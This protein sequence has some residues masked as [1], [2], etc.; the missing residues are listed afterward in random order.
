MPA[1]DFVVMKGDEQVR[2]GTVAAESKKK[3]E[4]F[5]DAIL[6]DKFWAYSNPEDYKERTTV[7]DEKGEVVREG[8]EFPGEAHDPDEL[9]VTVTERE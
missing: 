6:A 4:Q 2:N 5:V 3:A 9:E 1:F 7:R 8:I